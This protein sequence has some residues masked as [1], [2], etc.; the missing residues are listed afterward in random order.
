MRLS[1]QS[2]SPPPPH[3]RVV[4]H[5]ALPPSLPSPRP[6]PSLPVGHL[7]GAM[8]CGL[9]ACKR[10]FIDW[11]RAERPFTRSHTRGIIR[12]Y[13]LARRVSDGAPP[14]PPGPVSGGR[15]RRSVSR[16]RVRLMRVNYAFYIHYGALFL[17]ASS[18][19]LSSWRVGATVHPSPDR[20]HILLYACCH[21]PRL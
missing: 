10:A 14:P 13:T 6:H 20:V 2:L 1:R 19:P 3:T 21:V 17:L 4:R 8:S 9:F 12:I 16:L 11:R 18:H 5:P 7:A 15:A